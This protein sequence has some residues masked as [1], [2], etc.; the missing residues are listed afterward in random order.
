[1]LLLG[2]FKIRYLVFDVKILFLLIL[3]FVLILCR[4]LFNVRS[5]LRCNEAWHYV[6]QL[7]DRL[8]NDCF[9]LKHLFSLS[10]HLVDN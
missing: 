4:S 9:K 3:L 8:C 7:V 2:A 6:V 1:M 10:L 5:R